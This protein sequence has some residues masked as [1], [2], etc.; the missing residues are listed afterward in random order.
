MLRPKF[1]V[2]LV[3]VA[4]ACAASGCRVRPVGAPAPHAEPPAP[5]PVV[6][7]TPEVTTT[8]SIP[9]NP[10]YTFSPEDEQFLDDLEHRI[11]D[12]FWN[13][14]Y[15]ETGIAI[16]HTENRI[17]KVAA[18]G[19]ELAALCIGVQRGWLTHDQGYERTLKI[20]ST[21]WGDPNDPAHPGVDGKFGLFWHF[22]DGKTGR[23]KPVDCVAV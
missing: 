1:A 19:F 9:C 8:P 16:D 3:L 13:E 4:L 21:F 22:V 20:L 10:L 2:T 12:Y 5:T 23:M 6:P 18:T 17:G 14:V 15:P 11:V 7:S